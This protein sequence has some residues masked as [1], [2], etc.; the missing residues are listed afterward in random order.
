MSQ[1][2]GGNS[3]APIIEDDINDQK[4]K[5]PQIFIDQ[6]LKLYSNGMIT[7]QEV[8]DNV[9]LIIFGGHHTSAFAVA[10][11]ILMLAMHSKIKHRV[12]D[13]LN[14][15]LGDQ[16][17]DAD[18][19]IEQINQLTY[20]EQVI[21][22][23][24][25]LYPVAPLLLRHCTEDTK[26]KN[27]VLPAG[28]EVIIS[29]MTVHRRKDIWGDDADEFN[30]D[31]FSK[32]AMSKRNP[33]SFMAFSNGTRYCPGQRFAFISIKIILAKLLR[34]YRISTHMRMDDIK[35][36]LEVTCKPIDGVM[37]EIKERI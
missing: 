28:T 18:L 22:E 2:Q 12:M 35:F 4:Y 31:H 8:R 37:I 10:F 17:V 11:S 24:L 27:F 15:V 26:L 21:K 14:H 34:K 33:Y 16:S 13:E 20:L 23:T 6:L 3:N 25:R 7:D 1:L 30:P 19:T 29:A 5:K 36:R 9:Q 32:E